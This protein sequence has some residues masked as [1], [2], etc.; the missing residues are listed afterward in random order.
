MNCIKCASQTPLILCTPEKPQIFMPTG[1]IFCR[2]CG[3][4]FKELTPNKI[5]WGCNVCQDYFVCSNCKLCS[6]GHSLFKCYSLVKKE[7]GGS[8]V[9]NMYNCDFC[10]VMSCVVKKDINYVWHCNPCNYDVCPQHFH[11]SKNKFLKDVSLDEV[12]KQIIDSK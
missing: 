5:F 9:D 6:E 7:V 10:G 12:K 2:G 1:K 4:L 3:Y 11:D 8:Y